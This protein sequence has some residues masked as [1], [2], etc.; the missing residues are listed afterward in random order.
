MM[1]RRVFVAPVLVVLGLSLALSVRAA[2]A[3]GAVS[4][5]VTLPPEAKSDGLK[6]VLVPETA[7]SGRLTVKVGK[8]GDYYF[9]IVPQGSWTLTVEGTDLVPTAIKVLVHDNESRQDLT[10]F[11]G[12][13]PAKQVF[14]VGANLKVT[15]DL[16]LGPVK[17]AAGSASGQVP[18]VV[19]NEEITS[20]LQSGDYAGALSK[21]DTALAQDAGNSALVYWR[22]FALFKLKRL[23]EAT[24]VIRQAQELKPDQVGC[25]WVM[26]A[27][28]SQQNKKAEAIAE[29]D[30]EIANPAT[31]PATRVNCYIN[32]GLLQRDLGNHE[33]SIAAFEKVIE[34]DKNQ[35][36]AYSYLAEQY[37]AAGQPAK[38]EEV[39]ARG[40]AVGAEDPKAVFNVGATYWN[41]KQFAKA[42]EAFRRAVTLDPSFSQAWKSLGY[43]LVNT[44]KLDE[45]ATALGKYLALEPGAADAAEVKKMI[46]EIQPH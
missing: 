20:L 46:K 13:P 15:Y 16:T 5:H 44:G 26:G 28:L 43:A 38:A 31:D 39:Q 34:L 23:D 40:R 33:A 14:D 7:R 35:S 8:K 22:G 10:N 37:L 32:M 30:K 21:I 25:H 36:E 1:I 2:H 19:S 17:P 42:E 12:P 4:G 41:D 45:A 3:E 6:I 18:G 11:A 27:I 29:F 9:G 24:A